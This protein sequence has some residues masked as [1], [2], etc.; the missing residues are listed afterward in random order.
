MKDD[1][2]A[3]WID[4][5][6]TPEE[7][8]ELGVRSDL[9]SAVPAPED[10]R[11][12][13]IIALRTM[14][15]ALQTSHGAEVSRLRSQVER[16]TGENEKLQVEV[17]ARGEVYGQMCGRL[18]ECC[19]KYKLGLGGEHVDELVVAEVERLRADLLTECPK[20]GESLR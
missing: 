10:P 5:E 2:V 12:K 11:D 16:M 14:F 18:H 13:E 19:Q 6:M 3:V 20:C 4:A 7:L 8:K 1:E 9:S 15:D 17:N